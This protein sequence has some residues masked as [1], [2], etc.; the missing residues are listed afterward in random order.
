MSKHRPANRGRA[1]PR[2]KTDDH[3]AGDEG[4][5]QTEELVNR[6]NAVA[7]F[8]MYTAPAMLTI[9]TSTGDEVALLA[10]EDARQACRPVSE[11]GWRSFTGYAAIC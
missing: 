2:R 1:R 3:G 9:L 8:A 10:A 6:R 11:H 5:E 4:A 7:R